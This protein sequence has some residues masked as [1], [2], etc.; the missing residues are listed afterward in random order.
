MV[1]KSTVGAE[2]DERSREILRLVIGSYIRSGEPVGSRTVSKVIPSRL[3]PA[4]IRNIMADLE[5]SGYLFQPHTSAGRAPSEKGYRFYVDCLGSSGKL[6]RSN[7]AYINQA[8]SEV[9]TPETMMA[10]ASYLLSDICHN[11]GIVVPPPIETSVIQHIEFVRL[12]DAKILVILVSKSGLLQ[13]KLIRVSEPYSQEELTRAGNYLVERFSGSTLPDIRRQLVSAMQQDRI[14]YDRMMR[15]L[16][17]TWAKT[18]SDSEEDGAAESA[19][20]QGTGNIISQVDLS[21]VDMMQELFR[22]FEEKGKLVKIL[23]ACLPDET[24][25]GVQVTIGSELGTPCMRDFTLITSPYVQREGV[26][27]VLGIIGP[28]RMEYR[29]GISVVLYL[30][31]AFSRRI[32]A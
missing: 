9:D 27:G 8:L 13:Q 14:L 11:V 21:D 30:A 1:Q 4:T 3:S 2:L 16:V 22:V 32:N 25:D 6:T 7:E 29:K 28:T 23:N 15:N 26:T 24:G 10:T 17:E 19:Y 20:V 18:L 12:D 31:N 5:E